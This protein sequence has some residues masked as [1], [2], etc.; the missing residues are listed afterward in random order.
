MSQRRPLCGA[1]GPAVCL[2]RCAGRKRSARRCPVA[3]LDGEKSS[4]RPVAEGAAWATALDLRLRHWVKGL[5]TVLGTACLGS[6]SLLAV[7]DLC[8]DCILWRALSS[9]ASYPRRLAVRMDLPLNRPYELC[10]RSKKPR[11]VTNWLTRELAALH[12][13]W[14]GPVPAILALPAQ[15]NT[16]DVSREPA[17]L[18][19][20]GRHTMPPQPLGLHLPGHRLA[21][22][23]LATPIAAG[24]HRQVCCHAS[25]PSPSAGT[26]FAATH[27]SRQPAATHT[28]LAAAPSRATTSG[29]E[30]RLSVVCMVRAA[31]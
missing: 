27:E 15:S 4:S 8:R 16:S 3:T 24:A 1:S 6:E 19:H 31:L 21:T 5:Q 20:F 30:S 29:R 26:S 9:D 28:A 10:S 13:A 25:Q 7:P 11:S 2:L 12:A 14:R 23:P 18:R 17:S 22:A